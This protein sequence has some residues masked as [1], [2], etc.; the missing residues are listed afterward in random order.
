MFTNQKLQQQGGALERSLE[1]L[2]VQ[3]RS[4][5]SGTGRGSRYAN[6]SSG[7]LWGTVTKF[8]PL[9]SQT[10]TQ[11]G[12]QVTHDRDGPGSSGDGGGGSGYSELNLEDIAVDLEAAAK[13]RGGW[14]AAAEQ[15][16]LVLQEKNDAFARRHLQVLVFE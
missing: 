14:W 16:H 10:F 13:L 5:G 15:S 1:G 9:I 11:W 2:R 7:K 4:T 3:I 8:K 6:S 12:W